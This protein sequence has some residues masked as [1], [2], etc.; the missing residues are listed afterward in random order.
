MHVTVQ[1]IAKR[2]LDDGFEVEFVQ[3]NAPLQ[4]SGEMGRDD[5]LIVSATS[6]PDPFSDSIISGQYV[7]P[8]SKAMQK[9]SRNRYRLALF[10]WPEMA[11]FSSAALDKL[12]AVRSRGPY[13][14]V[15]A[16]EKGGLALAMKLRLNC[17]N[18]I[19]YYSLELYTKDHPL[20]SFDVRM[21]ALRR[22]ERKYSRDVSMFV[23]QDDS[24]WDVLKRDLQLPSD[25]LK[26]LFP[27]SE[28]AEIVERSRYL[29]E[30]LG[31]PDQSK[32]LLYFGAVRP[33]RGVLEI[34]ECADRLP[35]GWFLVFHGPCD[36]RVRR[37]LEK[38]SK[39]EKIR[40]SRD[41]VQVRDRALLI[42]S[43]DAGLAIYGE[44]SLNDRLTG[45]SSEKVALYLKCGLPVI[46]RRNQSYSHIEA[47]GAGVLLDSIDDIPKAVRS[48]D[49]NLRQFSQSA[50]RLFF[51]RYTFEKNVSSLLR[52][53]GV[54]QSGVKASS[55]GHKFLG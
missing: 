44:T 7:G 22:I 52:A 29:R 51:E 28:P 21:R 6:D 45:F 26:T 8:V 12:S 48:I 1:Y 16:V 11:I 25:S 20:I 2:L 18:P 49:S 31:L 36:D 41:M 50:Q 23:I 19:V 5:K 4:F 33:E 55:P 13:E 47:A 34:A 43:A 39:R 27:V 53:L 38:V 10:L 17:G 37:S 42:A 40:L 54:L 30:R 35:D 3:H 9:F 14:F 24:R 15:I 46:A 32:I